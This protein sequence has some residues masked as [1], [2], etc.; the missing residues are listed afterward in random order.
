MGMKMIVEDIYSVNKGSLKDV[1]VYF[2]GFCIGEVIF[3]QGFVLINY[4]CGYG[5]IQSYFFLENN[6]LEDGFWAM[7]W[8]QE[9]FNFGLFVIFIV[10]IEDVMDL[11]LNNVIEDMDVKMWQFWV[12]KNMKEVIVVVKM[13]DYQEVMVCDFFEGIKYYMFV[14]EIYWDICLVGVLFLLIGKFGVDIDNWVWLWYIGDFFFFCIYVSLDNKL[15]EYSEENV[16]FKFCYY[17]LIFLDGVEE[18][19]F[20]LV[21]GFFGCIEEYLLVVVIEQWVDVVN[22]IWIGICDC[23]LNVVNVVMQVDLGVC[24][25]YVFK[26]FCIV[27]YWKKWIGENQG[28]KVMDGVGCKK[29][30]EVEFRECVMGNFEWCEKYGS[31]LSSF[32]CLYGDFEFYVV[33]NIVVGEIVGCNIELF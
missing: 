8:K 30:Y 11:V 7:N 21:F 20:I 10:C 1:I 33:I 26:Q 6:Y 31:L 2:G 17:L 23:V 5:Q 9:I 22:F 4:Y 15:A 18:D 28:I 13:E 32:E 19:D 25:K 14:M 27:N 29:V 12:D 16:F 3:D 24:I